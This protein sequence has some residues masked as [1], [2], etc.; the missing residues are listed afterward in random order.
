MSS[1]QNDINNTINLNNYEEFFILYMDNEL[2]AEQIKMVDDFLL[3]NPA[4]RSEL[5]SLLNTRL[6]VEEMNFSN[7]EDLFSEAMKLNVADES[8]LLYIDN[9]LSSVQQK[10][11]ENKLNENKE[12]QTEYKLLLQTKLDASEQI[13]YPYKN[14]LYRKTDKVI[15]VKIW[16]RIAAI[17]LL[18]ICSGIL[19][20]F[21]TE[22]SNHVPSNIVKVKTVPEQPDNKL[23]QNLVERTKTAFPKP[24]KKQD[25]AKQPER[26]FNKDIHQIKVEGNKNNVAKAANKS[27]RKYINEPVIKFPVTKSPVN[28]IALT[29]RTNSID[30][31]MISVTQP[32]P[33]QN[34]TTNY[35][36]LVT[37]SHPARITNEQ[38]TQEKTDPNKNSI[39]ANDRKGS[40]KSFLRKAT[41]IIEKRTGID[42]SNDNDELLI[43][44]VAVK[45]K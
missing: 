23:N 13:I 8:L 25:V 7:K 15:P 26:R 3:S 27:N 1:K 17:L 28:E 37:S 6:P 31:K 14:D 24:E 41:R 9:E 39:A 16:M 30:S 34:T 21:S 45:L 2:D 19:Y 40:L 11:L 43:G 10:D 33:D 12:L 32:I 35:S 5:D 36:S 4:L 20:F 38:A 29:D 42:P 22:R 44:A 18:I